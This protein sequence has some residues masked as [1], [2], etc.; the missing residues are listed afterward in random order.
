MKLW[1]KRSFIC[2]NF[3]SLHKVPFFLNLKLFLTYY[4]KVIPSQKKQCEFI[5]S[6]LK[7]TQILFL[8]RFHGS[9]DGITCN[10]VGEIEISYENTGNDKGI[11]IQ[12]RLL[13]I[14]L[15]SDR[16]VLSTDDCNP[17]I[18][19]IP[20]FIFEQFFIIRHFNI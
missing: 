12:R 18:K 6:T 19:K 4:Q 15:N 14:P 7:Q 20:L 5:R 16:I 1:T 3:K 17:W 13:S 10:L 2:V 8:A 9:L 11:Y